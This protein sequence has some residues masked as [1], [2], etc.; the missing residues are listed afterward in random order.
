MKKNPLVLLL[1]ISGA[2]FSLF[3]VFV[4]F[5]MGSFVK[6]GKT[7]FLNRGA[8][9]GVLPIDGVIMDSQKTLKQ[10]KKYEENDEIKGVIVRINSPGG[11]VAPSQEIYEAL[12]RLKKVKPVISSFDSLAASGG[13][14]IAVA[15]DKIIT[16]PGTMTGS[17]G[18][19]MEFANLSEL[20]K[21][22]KVD[23]YNIKSGKFKD[24]GSESRAMSPEEKQVMQDMVMSVY[25]Q[26]VRAV[27]TGRKLSVERVKEL[28]DGRIYTGEQA[29]KYGLADKLGGLEVA[30]E[31]MKVLAK[32][33]GKPVMVYPESKKRSIVELFTSGVSEGIV[34]SVFNALGLS[35][36]LAKSRALL[37]NHG[38]QANLMFL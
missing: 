21:W 35:E 4:F 28:A 18:V 25:E 31:E 33:K 5:A 27:A 15:T 34:H 22:A 12:Q 7:S 1:G 13:Y 3:L 10:I 11:A 16:N 19:I 6:E 20:Y 24:V 37:G 36:P 23:R 29:V 30:L 8:S 2:F 9:V 32:I 38:N 26:F 14:Y 17:I